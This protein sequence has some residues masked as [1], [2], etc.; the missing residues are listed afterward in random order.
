MVIVTFCL[1]DVCELW[2]DSDI[3]K[4]IVLKIQQRRP[5]E[6]TGLMGIGEAISDVAGCE[7]D[8][9][10]QRYRTLLSKVFNV[11]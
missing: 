3:L 7:V 10:L 1:D 8:A 5:T 11:H 9:I 2:L 4:N 6:E